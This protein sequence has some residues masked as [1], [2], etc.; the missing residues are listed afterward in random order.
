MDK[1]SSATRRKI[2]II[3]KN[4]GPNWRE[5]YPHRKIDSIY[6]EIVGDNRKNLFCKIRPETKTRLDEMVDHYG[7]PMSE[8]IQRLI[9]DHF[10]DFEHERN[11]AVEQIV[12]QYTR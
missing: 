1:Y 5:L 11:V 3:T 12:Q 4:V 9:D 7:I 2:A 6:N 8:L 10:A